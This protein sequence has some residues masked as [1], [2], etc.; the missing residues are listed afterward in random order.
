MWFAPFIKIKKNVLVLPSGLEIKYPNLRQIG[1]EW[2]YDTY[3]KV[4]EAETTKLYGGK[5]IENICQALAGELCKEA[6]ERALIAGLHPVGA[7]HDEI[8]CIDADPD[9]A[10]GKLKQCMEYSPPWMP[11]LRLK[12]EV[13]A[14]PNW[15]EAKS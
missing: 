12:A 8:L 6:I 4:Y 9:C 15:N 3:K 10:T 2:V 11:S 5:M 13:G 14:G 7:V 1:D